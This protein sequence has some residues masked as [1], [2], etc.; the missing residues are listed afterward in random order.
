M[1]VSV[2]TTQG[3]ERRLTIT[4]PAESVDN[5]VKSR[6]QQLAKTQRINGFRPGKVP[7][8]VIKKRYGQAVR[9]EVAGD[10]MQ[11]NFYQAIVQEK[12]NPAGMPSFELTKDQDGED[13]EFVAKFEVYPEVEVKGVDDIEIEKTVVEIADEDLDNMLETLQKQHGEWKEVK[14]K[15]R[16]DDRM[17]IDFVGTIDGEEFDG[18]KAEDFTLE[19]G[20]DRMIPGFEK[21]L[22]GAKKGEEVIVDVTFPEDYHAEALKGKEA[23]FTVNVKKVEGLTLPKVD[24]EFAK[25]F[26]IEDG[27][28][29]A[30]KAEVRK[31]MERELG[32]TLKTQL[33]EEV[34]AKLLEKNELDLPAALVDQEVNALREQAKQ[35]F[36]QQGGGQNLPD[37]PA[38]LFK[39]NA[40]RRVS[41]GLLLGEIIKQNDLK[42]DQ[43]KV[44]SL[45]ETMASAY[46]DPQE[47]VDYYKNNQ[48]LMQQ[49][50]NVALEEQAIEWVVGQAKVTEVNKPFDE[51]MNKQG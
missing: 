43:E 17:V 1:Q 42:A 31:N 12:I 24:E 25:L 32:Q 14:R 9:Q 13:L 41:I 37:L 8:S 34:I 11:Q 20:K 27:D 39:D 5:A 15:A 22:V 36:S 16:K 28:V 29:E 50:Q 49:M 23:Q 19:L 46:E 7:V 44:D 21:P 10:V 38:D 48:E 33:K 18:G 4:V 35:R 40:Q 26:G 30:L 51:V 2:E 45:I 3:L 47:V 6:L